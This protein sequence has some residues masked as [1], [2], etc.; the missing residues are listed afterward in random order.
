[1]VQTCKRS[2]LP[3]KL[4]SASLLVIILLILTLFPLTIAGEITNG[5]ATLSSLEDPALLNGEWKIRFY[6]EYKS[7]REL[8][9][10]QETP[11][12]IIRMPGS[13]ISFVQEKFGEEHYKGYAHLHL[14]IKLSETIEKEK[15]VILS[16]PISIAD[17]TYFNGFLI[18]E[19]GVFPP[20]FFSA[21]NTYRF[22]D[23]HPDFVKPGKNNTLD[24][25]FYYY[26]DGFINGD[27][28]LGEM[29]DLE[30]EYDLKHF[31][32]NRIHI[33]L[34]AMILSFALYYI[35]IFFMRPKQKE[36]LYFFIASI[37]LSISSVNF[38]LEDPI[39]SFLVKEKFSFSTSFLI[40]GAFV[41]YV[42]EYFK[43]LGSNQKSGLLL[44]RKIIRYFSIVFTSLTS[45][46][47]F[48]MPSVLMINVVNGYTMPF[49]IIP[50][51]YI[52]FEV[53]YASIKGDRYAIFIAITLFILL[54]FIVHDIILNLSVDRT[55]I[56]L[57]GLALPLFLI[58]LAISLGHRI[59]SVYI[60]LD[61]SQSELIKSNDTIKRMNEDLEKTVEE[62]TQQ[63]QE[64]NTTLKDK[65][66]QL[67]R[68]LNVAK[69]VQESILPH[70]GLETSYLIS[71]FAFKPMTEMS[72][73]FY[74]Q[75]QKPD[76]RIGFLIADVSGHGVP[77]ALIM[78]MAKTVFTEAWHSGNNSAAICQQVNQ[79]LTPTLQE[80]G[81]FLTA[82]LIIIDPKTLKMDFTNAG[83][84]PILI[85]STQ[86]GQYNFIEG[87][88]IIMG[89]DP[90]YS[91][92]HSQ[93]QLRPG[94]RLYLYTDGIVESRNELKEEF[95]EE[96]FAEALKQG[97][98]LTL[99]ESINQLFTI[100]DD[101]C[102]GEPQRDDRTIL[103]IEI[104]EALQ[105]EKEQ[106]NRQDS[107]S[108]R[109]TTEEADKKEME[110][111]P[112]ELEEFTEDFEEDKSFHIVYNQAREKIDQDQLE[113]AEKM[114]SEVLEKKPNLAPALSLLGLI[115]Q[116]QRKLEKAMDFYN[117][118]K[119]SSPYYVPN[120]YRMGV[121]SL[122]QE[123]Y[124]N[125][126]NIFKSVEAI[127]PTFRKVQY[128]LNVLKQISN[129]IDF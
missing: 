94:D 85:I 78:S 30:G 61:E 43:V 19:K 64:S 63:L 11:F 33:V 50:F 27:I 38:F 18:G 99:Q 84:H 42:Q 123:D 112:L 69:L 21:W 47:I 104:R 16:G 23:I 114:L 4:K 124:S 109:H 76:G 6:D 113:E 106:T 44:F 120:L 45:L 86:D 75:Y 111:I 13:I 55:G 79:R 14:D 15:Y 60:A 125:A 56:Y 83:H 119:I 34:I 28:K 71:A 2:Y 108:I 89:I 10:D 25:F 40:I 66:D 88:D 20:D 57:H 100:L 24:I 8:E 22:Y 52:V 116:K 73:D 72:G 95:E 87:D 81:F 68:E 59:F 12:E 26:L 129:S 74:D 67:T 35:I 39:V 51:S 91:F 32:T 9:M 49:I 7:Y 115:A 58:G 110:T 103:A 102:Q 48:A 82:L 96:R 93:Y 37:I 117:K 46:L 98:P 92:N 3:F 80:S 77:S 29:E 118:A 53:L 97:I 1:M 70:N 17:K 121:L 127:D 54:G 122:N 31:I 90:D 105:S 62:R 5:Q 126:Y 101:Y 65:M 36:P 41:L 128:Y 107:H